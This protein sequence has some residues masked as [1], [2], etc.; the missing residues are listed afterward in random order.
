M[1]IQFSA[2]I[3]ERNEAA[4]CMT[5]LYK[6]QGFKDVEVGV[7]FPYIGESI[8]SLLALAAPMET[9]AAEVGK[10]VMVEPG[11]VG[12][13]FSVEVGD[14]DAQIDMTTPSTALADRM[15]RM[16]DQRL[17]DSDW[18]Q[19]PDASVTPQELALWREYRALL[20]T[21]PQQAGFP[22]SIQWPLSPDAEPR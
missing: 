8:D 5:V 11:V 10:V 7:R 14:P 18:T 16:R 20:R 2:T 9:W 21:V 12:Q 3:K 22:T 6:R 15:R 1:K 4:K 17:A 19:L 13:T